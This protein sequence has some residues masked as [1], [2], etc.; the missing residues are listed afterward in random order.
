MIRVEIIANHSV[1][2]NILEAFSREGVGKF[3]TK[4]PNVFGIGNSGPRMGDAVWPEENLA[5]VVWCE[6]DEARGIAQA[7]DEVK[8]QFP[9]EGIRVFGLPVQQNCFPQGTFYPG[10]GP[11][12]GVGQGPG[13]GPAQ[14]TVFAQPEVPTEPSSVPP[15]TVPSSGTVRHDAAVPSRAPLD[16]ISPPPQV[17]AYAPPVYSS[18]ATPLP[19]AAGP[20]INTEYDGQNMDEEH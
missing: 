2:E 12:Q 13:A 9:D 7:V 14:D 4:Y 1:E 11:G 20:G 19:A 17:P 18:P 5:L 10:A 16:P 6:E 8:K 3:Y 15:Y